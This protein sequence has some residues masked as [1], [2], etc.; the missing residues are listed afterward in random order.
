MDCSVLP[1]ELTATPQPLVGFCGLDTAKNS[2]HKSIWDAFNANRKNDR[3]HLQFKLIPTN[4]EF[5]VSKPKRQSYEWYHPKGILKRNWILKHL[6]IL[7]AV[8][9]TFHSIELSDPTWAEKQLQC[10]SAVQTLRNSLQGRL[11]RL[12]IVLIQSGS[13]GRVPGDELATTERISNLASA[14]DVS[15]KMIF[16]LN[17]S[18][19][20]MGHI[21]RLESAFLDVAQSYYTQII[22]QIKMHRDQ[23]SANHQVL[24]IRHQFKLGFMS[25]MLH[26]FT[27]ALKYYT[28]AYMILEDIRVVDTNC[29][30]IKTV[31]GFLS[32][33]RSRLMFKMNV[34]RDAITQFN[35]HIELYKGKTGSR[36]LL[37]EHYGWL[38]VQFSSFGDL[39]CDAIKGGLPALQTQH[40]GIYYFRAAEFTAKRNEAFLNCSKMTTVQAVDKS[41]SN[42][43]YSDFFGVRGNKTGEMVNEQ[44]ILNILYANEKEFNHSG[45]IISYLGQAMA[46]YKIYKCLR[47]RKKLA[48]NM[49][50]EYLKSGDHAKALTLFSLMLSDYRTDKWYKIFTEVLMK[51]FLSAYYSASVPDYVSCSIEAMSPRI[52]AS[53]SDR[54]AILEN[55]WRVFQGVVPTCIQQP[56]AVD[57]TQAWEHALDKFTEPVI[58]DLDKISDL[59]ACGVSFAESQAIFDEE[60]TIELNIK[61]LTEVPLKI[62]G[63]SVVLNSPKLSVKLKAKKVIQ[64]TPTSNEA[65]EEL[66]DPEL[67]VVPEAAYRALFSVDSRQFTENDKLTIGRVEL[68]IGTERRFAVLLKSTT[69]NQQQIFKDKSSSCDASKAT[70]TSCY[71]VP[72]YQMAAQVNLSDEPMLMNEF[73]RVVINLYNNFDS[74]L[75]NV[76]LSVTVPLHL[77][78]KVFLATDITEPR[79]TLYSTIQ[80]DVGAKAL[81]SSTS[82]VYY[83]I[84]LVRGNI[85]LTQ[86]MWYQITSMASIVREPTGYS[87]EKFVPFDTESPTHQKNVEKS[88]DGGVNHNIKIEYE[89]NCVRKTKED[90]IMIPCQD[91]IQLTATFYTLNRKVLFKAYQDEDFILRIQMEVKATCDIDILD[92]TLHIADNI[93]IRD[94]VKYPKISGKSLKCGA[95]LE[96][97]RIISVQNKKDDLAIL[98]RYMNI[99]HS[100]VTNPTKDER[101]KSAIPVA[102]E[103]PASQVMA[104]TIK[105]IYGKTMEPRVQDKDVAN[106]AGSEAMGVYVVRW[107]RTNTT[108]VNESKFSISGLEVIEP[109]LNI[110]CFILEKVYVRVPFELRIQVK[111]PGSKILN[112]QATLDNSDSFMFSGHRQ[113]NVSIFSYATHDLIFILYPLKS[114]WQSIP[115]LFLKY[116]SG[117]S[118]GAKEEITQSELNL[119]V[120]RWMPKRV[121]VHPPHR[122]A[123]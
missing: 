36:E 35:A 30:E 61:S 116:L 7:P 3:L 2:V 32:Y 86:K 102:K 66:K 23:L 44:N 92:A 8:V 29:T 122:V 71:I 68:Q 4:Y 88:N 50:E 74:C 80:I 108:T 112:L 119:Y 27:T 93:K 26:D 57:V 113:L 14:C 87:G 19:H 120:Q 6:H 73:Y 83:V 59:F 47:F 13:S 56:P 22:K 75:D 106:E 118:D 60:I 114:G 89:E 90:T 81:Q 70:N 18:D 72:T 46:Q 95:R 49:A 11:S 101:F 111:N 97:S 21:L 31:A 64:F 121:F 63:I 91:E 15:P 110:Y 96:D 100:S 58:V 98:M 17:H 76:G 109:K 39:F 33:K 55:L 67:M 48:V 12:A 41:S 94:S 28:Q 69:L 123:E 38:C 24:K 25:E 5:P 117:G 40:P 105:S 51:T 62:R 9:V 115:Q 78:N 77:R 52:I 104:T 34:P 43:L 16:V 85:E 20:L 84:S 107:R 79:K 53:K 65:G 45:A 54:I 99:N 1:P 103:N 37:F 42:L 10:T 82:L